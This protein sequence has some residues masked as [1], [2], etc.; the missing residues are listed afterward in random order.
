MKPSGFATWLLVLS[1]LGAALAA[2]G[3]TSPVLGPARPSIS[4]GASSFPAALSR[5]GRY[6]L[7]LSRANNLS[8]SDGRNAWLDVF[9]RDRVGGITTLVSVD[10]GGAGGAGGGNGDSFTPGLSTNGLWVAFESVAGNLV[11]NDTNGLSDVFLRDLATGST[12][13]VSS[14]AGGGSAN[15]ASENPQISEDGRYVVYESQAGNLVPDDLNGARDIFRHDRIDQSQLRVSVASELPGLNVPNHG[16]AHSPSMTPDG[17]QVAY[18]K[19]LTN[20]FGRV[21]WRGD[22]RLGR[23]DVRHGLD[24]RGSAGRPGRAGNVL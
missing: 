15:G 4:A 11:T 23:P 22:P 9:L 10:A 7:F 1:P 18:V 19:S 20:E 5:D 14:A 16:P 24:Q 2:P 8:S 21:V 6:V 17:R 3:E 12:R 13:R